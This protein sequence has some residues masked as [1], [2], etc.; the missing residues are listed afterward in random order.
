MHDGREGTRSHESVPAATKVFPWPRKGPRLP[1]SSEGQGRLPFQRPPGRRLS[2]GT[3]LATTL[4]QIPP[5]WTGEEDL[6]GPG[7]HS[8][9][10]LAGAQTQGVA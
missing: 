8:N 5:K 2:A 4:S 6:H 1:K 9:Q 10:P 3:R 7:G